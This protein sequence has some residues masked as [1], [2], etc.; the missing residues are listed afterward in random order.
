MEHLPQLVIATNL[1]VRISYNPSL[2]AF[3]LD[4]LG[5]DL[6]FIICSVLISGFSLIIGQGWLLS[7]T[8]HFTQNPITLWQKKLQAFCEKISGNQAQS[9][10]S[11]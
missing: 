11:P 1:L 4:L 8:I 9:D 3:Y 7:L 6:D 2:E 10:T 5:G